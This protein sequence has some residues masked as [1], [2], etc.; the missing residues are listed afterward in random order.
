[1]KRLQSPLSPEDVQSLTLGDMVYLDGTV[2]TGRDKVH[3]RA[4]WNREQGEPVPDILTNATLFHCGPIMR[5]DGEG[6]EALALGPTTSARMDSLEPDMIKAFNLR[7]I[8]GKGGMSQETLQ[9]MQEVGCVYLAATGGAAVSLSEGIKE[10]LGRDWEDLGMAEAMWI[11][12]AERFGPFIVAM[13]AH[14]N[15]LY[16]KVKARVVENMRR[17][18]GN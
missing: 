5:P 10:E 11:V 1:M 12:R 8:I 3:M 18:Q 14:G 13:D 2:L 6:W 17:L 16:E 9:A 7:A 15:S 4:L